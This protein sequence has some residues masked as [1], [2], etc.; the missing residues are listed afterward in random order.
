MVAAIVC[1]QRGLNVAGLWFGSLGRLVA[2]TGKVTGNYQAQPG[3]RC[4]PPR[5]QPWERMM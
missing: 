5:D 3:Q 2:F 1:C 4:F